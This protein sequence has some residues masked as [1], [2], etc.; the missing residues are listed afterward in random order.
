MDDEILLECLELM[1]TNL[2]VPQVRIAEM[3]G[4]SSKA[5]SDVIAK[6]RRPTWKMRVVIAVLYGL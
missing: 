2:G 5:L 3:F 6:R 4:V 1:I